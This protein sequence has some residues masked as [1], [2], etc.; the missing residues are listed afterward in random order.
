MEK[1][2]F[3]YNSAD[4]IHK[5]H[6]VRYMPDNKPAAVLQIAHG[7][8]EFFER[9]EPFCEFLAKN[10][11]CVVGNDHLGHGKSVASND[12][13]GYF[14]DK[15]G[16]A[17]LIKDM[18]SLRLGVTKEMKELYNEDI[19]VFM[20]G[21][22]FGSLLT[23]KYLTYYSEGLCGAILSGTVFKPLIISELALL[24]TKIAAKENSGDRYRSEFINNLSVGSYAKAFKDENIKNAWLTRDVEVVKAYNADYR[25]NFIFTCGAYKDMFMLLNDIDT[26]TGANGINPD[27]KIRVMSGSCDVANEMGKASRRLLKQFKK[28][29]LQNVSFKEYK[30]MRHETLNEIGKEEVWNDVLVFINESVT[31]CTP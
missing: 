18:H 15:D 24:F 9:Y 11:I 10:G 17:I 2:V 20:M 8:N 12:E 3:E 16:A 5:I 26:K 29:G 27:L 6:A 14:A 31:S 23:R 21:H 19:P 4:Q 7:M 1:F 28:Q 22:S 30:D 25:C 13:L